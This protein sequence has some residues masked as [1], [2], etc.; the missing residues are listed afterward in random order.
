MLLILCSFCSPLLWLQV[1]FSEAMKLADSEYA[2][3]DAAAKAE[4]LKVRVT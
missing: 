2:G 1:K 4:T 3:A